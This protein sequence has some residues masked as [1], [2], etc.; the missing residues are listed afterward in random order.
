[1]S[2]TIRSTA[3]RF[4]ADAAPRANACARSCASLAA[5]ASRKAATPAIAAPAPCWLDGEPVHSCLFPRLSRR[6]HERHHDRRPRAK[7][8]TLH[9]M[10]QAFLQA[11]GFQCGFCTPGMIMTAASLNQAQ[12]QDLPARSKAIFAA[13]PAIARSRTLSA[14][15]ARSRTA[16][17]GDACGRSLPAPAARAD[18]H[19]HCALHARFCDRRACCI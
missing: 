9:P 19:R 18:R 13:A 3:K 17:A 4:S 16:E 12:R 6:G 14:A 10:Q 5:S 1:M 8:A 7:T 15:S 2:M 11:Q